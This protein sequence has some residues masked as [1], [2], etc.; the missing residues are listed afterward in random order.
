MVSTGFSV[1]SVPSVS[2]SVVSAKPGSDGT[3]TS[4]KARVIAKKR[5]TNSLF[6]FPPVTSIILYG[7]YYTS[8]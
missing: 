5:L 8:Y 4:N 7:N 3:T 6:M 1:S 2:G